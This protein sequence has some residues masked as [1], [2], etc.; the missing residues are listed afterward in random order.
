MVGEPNPKVDWFFNKPSLWQQEFGKLREIILSTGLAEELK[1]GCPCYTLNGK[2]IVL[3]HGFKEYCAILFMKGAL[4]KDS[5]GV[6][7]QQTAN[8]QS[9]RHMRF[10]CLADIRGLEDTI[11]RYI[12]GAIEIERTGLKVVLKESLEFEVAEEF[13]R[14]LGDD[15]Q[16]KAAFDALTPGRQRGFLLHFSS[17]KQSKTRE[18]RI[19]K[20]RPLIFAGKGLHDDK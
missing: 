4:L 5:M 20:C 2:N 10:E 6:L 1:W 11:K 17:A 9:A 19:R 12:E 13:A 14:A 16:L 15:P 18:E 7:I 3:I 8:V